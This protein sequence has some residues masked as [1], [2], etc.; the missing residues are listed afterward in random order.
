MNRKRQ[1]KDTSFMSK[2]H[3]NRITKQESEMICNVLSISHVS[4]IN[5]H[6]CMKNS[7]HVST[8]DCDIPIDEN[9][10][11]NDNMNETTE[12]IN[13]N[14]VQ[15]NE[16][17]ETS[18]SSLFSEESIFYL[19]ENIDTTDSNIANDIAM[20]AVKYQISHPR[21]QEIRTVAPGSYY[22]FGVNSISKILASVKDNI[23][24]IKITVNIDGLPLSKSSLQQFWPILGSVVPYNNVFVIGLY[25]GNEKPANVNDFLKDFVDETKALCE[26]GINFNGRN[27]P[28]R[29]E[30]LICNTA[31]SFVLCV[32]G[33]SGYFSCTKCQTEGEYVG[34]RICFPQVDAPLRTDNDFIEKI[35]D[36]YHKPNITCNLLKVPHF[37]PVTNVPLDYMYL[38]CLG[39]MR[40]LI[41]LWLEGDLKYQL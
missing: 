39:I 11:N 9:I 15:M 35:D 17:N 33:H 1:R 36:N 26:N 6:N 4:N 30:A 5:T 7:A 3:L 20:W 41:Y 28:C 18:D 16:A 27:I 14:F 29:L 40:K 12:L 31:K 37:K 34:H 10:A 2:R 23:D 25:H 19:S 8:M 32:K 22:H 24:C 21:K 38:I 13:D